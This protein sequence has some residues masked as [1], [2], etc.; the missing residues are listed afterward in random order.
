MSII[1][2]INSGMLKIILN[3]KIENMYKAYYE[4]ENIKN[5][6]E[7]SFSN[8]YE[9]EDLEKIG[10]FENNI[11]KFQYICGDVFLLVMNLGI[12]HY[13]KVSENEDWIS[14]ENTYLLKENLENIESYNEFQQKYSLIIEKIQDFKLIYEISVI[15]GLKLK[16]LLEELEITLSDLLRL[17]RKFLI[18]ETK[19]LQKKYQEV[20]DKIE[21]TSEKNKRLTK[22]IEKTRKKNEKH[23]K[24]YDKRILEL[25]GIFL[26]IFSVI[27]L[28]V[29]GILNIQ[30]NLPTNILL[31]MGS[32]LIVVTLLFALIK[33]DSKN[34]YK[35]WILII[36]GINLIL[37]GI[38]FY[39]P[40][41]KN[42]EEA[43]IKIENLE[44]KLDY[45]KRINELEKKTK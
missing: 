35:F 23:Q 16:M 13:K 32:I 25:M 43:K 26:S 30:D 5:I 15:L 9:K 18:N 2:K 40:V 20:A 39:N 38:F 29:T 37:T 19:D 36:F 27:G 34:K 22:E 8:L 10:I 28:G 11:N 7:I 3:R 17:E 21:K 14:S 45:E 12:Y 6:N 44:K 31:I 4:S 24:E 41:D 42:W 33:Y 1:H